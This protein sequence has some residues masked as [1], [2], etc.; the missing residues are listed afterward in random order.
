MPKSLPF[1][2]VSG[3]VLS[4]LLAS[5]AFFIKNLVSKI[6]TTETSVWELRVKI[7]GLT[8]R[9]G[10]CGRFKNRGATYVGKSVPKGCPYEA[11]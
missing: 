8:T 2:V 1:E 4:G 9:L 6:E 10:E 11:L 7:E 3:I 5:N